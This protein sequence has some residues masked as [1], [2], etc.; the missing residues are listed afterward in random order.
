MEMSIVPTPPVTTTPLTAFFYKCSSCKRD[1]KFEYAE[2]K[3][4][5]PVC[6]T[7]TELPIHYQTHLQNRTPV[8]DAI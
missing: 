3:Q 5:C 1:L 7:V 4:T 8:T 6:H 2:Q